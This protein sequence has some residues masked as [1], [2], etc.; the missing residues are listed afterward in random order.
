MDDGSVRRL[1]CHVAP[2]TGRSFVVPE[3][4]D[5]L[6]AASRKE[7]LKRWAGFK[8]TAMVVMGP[9]PAEFK[10]KVQ[11][12][13]L[14]EKKAKAETE[15]KRKAAEEER[16]RI[17]DE[18]KKKK[19]EEARK[20]AK[21]GEDDEAKEDEEAKEEEPA[22]TEEPEVVVELTEE[23]KQMSFRKGSLPD[24]SEATLAKCFAEFSLPAKEEGFD[25]VVFKWH[26]EAEAAKVLKEWIFAK[27]LTQRVDDLQPGQAF[28]DTWGEWTK[29]LASWR[30]LQSEWKDPTKRKALLAKRA[31]AKKKAAEEK[32]EE[33]PAEEEK[34]D[35]DIEDL[36]VF[37]VEDV[38]DIGTG[39]PLF[40]NF[41][42]EDWLLL[43]TRYELHLLLHSFKK[44]LDDPDRPSFMQ[45][46]LSFYF[47]KYF[48]KNFSVKSFAVEKF[49]DFL[50]LVKDTLAVK[51]SF[52]QAVLSEDTP[53]TN[54]VKLT[55]DHRR[56]RQRRLDA[57]DET[58]ELKFPRSAPVPPPRQG[59]PQHG[60]SSRPGDRRPQSSSYSSR[61]G[62]GRESYNS[63]RGGGYEGSGQ[64]RPYSST[65]GGSYYGS[66]AKHARTSSYGGSSYSGGGG[67][68]GGGY[69]G[70][71]GRR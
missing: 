10:E 41:A 67:G 1:L 39:E 54:F 53:V 69:G 16:K 50:E 55:E 56:E 71:Y 25:E 61:P 64:K 27:K 24:M 60:S 26:G 40:A 19:A 34:M 38:T 58:A 21:K 32:G 14:A 30:K 5:N 48:K 70:S 66:G 44:D 7:S 43:A 59:A 42:F 63:S 17:I 57:G 51:D 3:L 9:P 65:G 15:R 13:I 68:G 49:E 46:D 29:N 62:G 22:K 6:L 33:P 31:E 18:K 28:K 20:A 23:E 11:A 36:D 12:L 37:G 52:L 8:K 45:K 4:K 2:T 47:N 35:I